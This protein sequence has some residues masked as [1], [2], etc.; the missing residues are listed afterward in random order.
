M[1]AGN[2]D[3]AGDGGCGAGMERIARVRCVRR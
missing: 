3:Q 1:F 2:L